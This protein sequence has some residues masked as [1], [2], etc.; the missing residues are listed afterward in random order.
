MSRAT[1]ALLGQKESSL[2]AFDIDY[3]VCNYLWKKKKK[4]DSANIIQLNLNITKSLRLALIYFVE[5]LF[6][7]SF[8]PSVQKLN[9]HLVVVSTRS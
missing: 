8:A 7:Q 9:V 6:D 4:M 5:I 3:L 2:S 1:F